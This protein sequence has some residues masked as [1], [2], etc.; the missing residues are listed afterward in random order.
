MAKLTTGARNALPKSTFALPGERKYP[1]PDS[2]HAKA[3]LSRAA[4][5]VKTGAI[6]PS[7]KATIDAKAHRKL[8]VSHWS[9]KD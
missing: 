4:H 7:E 2:G 5:A 9:G 1:I 8:G 3:A 6:T